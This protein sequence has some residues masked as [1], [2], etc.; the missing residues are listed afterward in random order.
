MFGA[1]V[2]FS[3]SFLMLLAFATSQ[4]HPFDPDPSFSGRQEDPRH[5]ADGRSQSPAPDLQLDPFLLTPTP[6]PSAST[7]GTSFSIWLLYNYKASCFDLDVVLLLVE[8]RTSII[9]TK[10]MM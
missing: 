4:V 10:V 1:M 5:V 7:P 9:F 8:A 2:T 6:S 3:F